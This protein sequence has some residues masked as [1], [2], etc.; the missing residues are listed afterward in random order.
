[1]VEPHVPNINVFSSKIGST[2]PGYWLRHTNIRSQQSVSSLK[3]L[4][5]VQC[6][7]SDDWVRVQWFFIILSILSYSLYQN[8]YVWSSIPS[9]WLVW[10]VNTYYLS[11]SWV[12]IIWL[13]VL[14][15][16]KN[17]K[18]NGKVYPIYYIMEN[19]T[20]WNHQPVIHYD[21]ATSKTSGA[22]SPGLTKELPWKPLQQATLRAPCAT[23]RPWPR[24]M[25][26]VECILLPTHDLPYF[27]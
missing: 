21:P 9:Y 15:I 27:F 26:H 8:G 24:A 4:S 14:T 23:W 10:L 11:L 20:H 3:I 18:V 19:K 2:L 17:M 16:L 22:R 6:G 5:R 25:L 13:V 12:V 1:M 7:L